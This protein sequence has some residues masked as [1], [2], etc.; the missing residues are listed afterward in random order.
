MDPRS[1]NPP[2]ASCKWCVRVR[3]ANGPDFIN[4]FP[5][6]SVALTVPRAHDD[7]SL[8]VQIQ[9]FDMKPNSQNIVVI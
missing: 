7:I 3:L 5:N 4:C 8:G 6:F 1:L 2:V 9:G